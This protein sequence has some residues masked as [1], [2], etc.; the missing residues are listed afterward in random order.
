[1]MREV[2]ICGGEEGILF[3]VFILSHVLFRR[4]CLR[5]EFSYVN[6]FVLSPVLYVVTQWDFFPLCH[7]SLASHSESPF[8]F[9]CKCSTVL[10]FQC[11]F[12]SQRIKI[13]SML[14]NAGVYGQN[15]SISIREAKHISLLLQT[16]ICKSVCLKVCRLWKFTLQFLLQI[17]REFVQMRLS[18]RKRDLN[19]PCLFSHSL[20]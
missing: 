15:T 20:N 10:C 9:C 18:S 19:S 12:F 4:I 7:L 3:Y 5:S 13:F 6:R 17:S 11:H 16:L 14:S 1:M 2:E 8:C